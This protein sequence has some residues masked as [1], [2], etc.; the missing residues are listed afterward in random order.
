MPRPPALDLPALQGASRL[1][2]DQL[3]KDA[4]ILPDLGDMLAN[5]TL[6]FQDS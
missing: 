1:L 4:Q 2:Q 5:R 6:L 3:I